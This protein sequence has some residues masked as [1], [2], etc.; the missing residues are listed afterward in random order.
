MCP[1]HPRMR[2]IRHLVQRHTQA[3]AS[4]DE[5]PTHLKALR[6]KTREFTLTPEFNLQFN[7]DTHPLNLEPKK[8]KPKKEVRQLPGR[9]PEM[10]LQEAA[11]L[12]GGPLPRRDGVGRGGRGWMFFA[13]L[14]LSS[15]RLGGT[16]KESW[17]EKWISGNNVFCVTTSIYCS[18]I[19]MNQN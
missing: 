5:S 18:L 12:Q 13:W 2:G 6:Q 9:N 4:R 15:K 3:G 7:E 17:H 16:R 19:K 8:T 1:S 14:S 11:L 10:R